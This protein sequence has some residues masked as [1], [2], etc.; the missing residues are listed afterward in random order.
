MQIHS[1]IAISGL[2]P[3]GF[4][5]SFAH[6]FLR[7]PKFHWCRIENVLSGQVLDGMV[8]KENESNES[9]KMHV[10]TIICLFYIIV[11]KV[12]PEWSRSGKI[13]LS[14]R[15]GRVVLDWNGAK[16]LPSNNA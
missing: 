12:A 4:D 5:C 15:R 8:D 10:E 13:F 7:F 9:A 6:W 3:I 11:L 14:A 2:R 1:P 16:N